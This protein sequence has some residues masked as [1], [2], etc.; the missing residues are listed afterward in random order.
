M[1]NFNIHCAY[2]IRQRNFHAFIPKFNADKPTFSPLRTIPFW[3]SRVK[4]KIVVLFHL[5]KELM[6]PKLPHTLAADNFYDDIC[7]E[8]N[9]EKIS[10]EH[11][12]NIND[13]GFYEC[14]DMY[15]TLGPRKLS[16]NT[17]MAL[18]SQYIGDCT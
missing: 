17:L 2:V 9:L 8:I 4:L 10:R 3:F 14:E 11:R 16:V 7:Y 18:G 12:W 5:R 15:G 1:S 6:S 13:T